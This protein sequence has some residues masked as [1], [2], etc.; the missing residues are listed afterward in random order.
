MANTLEAIK[1]QSAI[2][3]HRSG[4]DLVDKTPFQNYQG[5]TVN[6]VIT[7]ARP[8]QT[9]PHAETAGTTLTAAE[10]SAGIVQVNPGDASQT[11]TLDN[12]T[13]LISGLDLAVEGASFDVSFINRS[14]NATNIAVDSSCDALHKGGT[15]L[16]ISVA[17][18]TAHTLR[19]RKIFASEG[20]SNTVEVIAIA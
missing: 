5:K 13:N 16:T 11:F 6:D 3:V 1:G 2:V 14:S 12:A 10:L 15:G 19:I 7:A 4:S 9:K 8:I 20:A 18:A 17:A